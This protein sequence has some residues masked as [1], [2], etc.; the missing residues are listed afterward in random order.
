MNVIAP[1]APARPSLTDAEIIGA[2]GRR[3]FLDGGYYAANGRVK[4]VLVRD[5]GSVVEAVVRGRAPRPYE[6]FILLG[7]HS[8][9]ATEIQGRC[10]CPVGSNCKH[11]AAA[12][13]YARQHHPLAPGAFD[14]TASAAPKPA[15]VPRPVPPPEPRSP[16]IDAWLGALARTE[17]ADSEEYPSNLRHRLLYVLGTVA[18]PNRMDRLAITPVSAQL[19]K[20]GSIG[21]GATPVPVGQWREGQRPRY[22]RPSD[23]LILKRLDARTPSKSPEDDPS[24]TL[25]RIIATG[26]AHWDDVNG[27]TLAEGPALPGRLRWRLNDDASQVAV[28]E[29]DGTARPIL[30][31]DPWYA[32]PASGTIGPI[33]L[34]LTDGLARHLLAA[35]PIP[36]A[37][38]PHVRAE[39][40]RRLTASSVPVPADLPEPEEIAEPP[41]PFLRL[42]EAK[43]PVMPNW[44]RF[45]PLREETVPMA[46]LGFRYGPV[47]VPIGHRADVV[48]RDGRLYRVRPEPE[49]EKDCQ[50]R[51]EELGFESLGEAFPFAHAHR[52]RH[53][54]LLG[55][56]DP[57]S[58][59]QF[60]ARD[61][62][63][64]RKDGWEIEI[65]A[66]FP[67]RVL[68]PDG[69]FTA[70]L[71]EG[72]GIDWLELHL[73]VTLA[74]ERVELVPALVGMI[75]QLGP[76]LADALPEA[77]DEQP[78]LV[79]LLDGR[80]L[81]VPL[82]R[83]R[84]ILT[85]LIEL[86]ARGGAGREDGRIGFTRFDVAEVAALQ[87]A[88]PELVWQGGEALRAL[89][90][91]LREAGGAIPSAPMPASFQG[92]LRAYQAQGVDWL[93][94]LGGAGLGG[95]LADDMGL[96]KTVQTLAHLA[97]E[98]HAGRLD[99]PAL[100]VCPTSL[101][102]N[103]SHEARRFAPDLRLLALHGPARKEQFDQIAAHDLVIT[104]YKLIARDHAVLTA[105]EWHAVVLD[106]AQAIKNPTAETTKLVGRLQAR[107]R[108]CLSGTPLENHLGELWS[109]FDFLAPG[110]L[111]SRDQFRA[112]Y[113]TPIEKYRD[114]R[115]RTMLAARVRPFLL[116]RA[117][118]QV[119]ADLPPKTEIVEPVEME[120][121]QRAIYESVRLAM[122]DRVREAIAARGL[123]RS[124]IVIL[125]A[126][127]KM[128]QACCDPRLLKLK[129]ARQAKAGS[130]KLERLMEML[131]EL[132]EEGR[133]VLVFSQ[134]TSMLALI[135]QRLAAA[136]IPLVLLTGETKDRTTPVARF[137]SGEVSLFLLSLKA[138]GTG[139]N[140]TAAD[141]VIH[142]DPWWNPA[143]EDQ[144]TD[145]AHRIG[146]DKP[147]FVHRLVA[148]GTIEEKMDELKSRKRA[149]VAGI[150][151]AEGG[152]PLALSEA[153]I[154]LL[155]G[156]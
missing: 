75:D 38:V 56:S 128:R 114:E 136:R 7:R 138:G 102:P 98:K 130:A 60:L 35:P 120:A 96:G 16:E 129:A 122:H 111:G 70:E 76:Q 14:R 116:R 110:F 17:E 12:L 36:A 66:D 47:L 80:I 91:Q 90:Q 34:D 106:E 133:R 135:E 77:S 15:A 127:L 149:L 103:W 86:F 65:A 81:S 37:Q 19:R 49:A 139:L 59:L 22:M 142:Y 63:V 10:S 73:G 119:A 92:A 62:P 5:G 121:G 123:A 145:R 23:C 124:G 72:S 85:A 71:S 115:R 41:R 55:D 45:Q 84:P 68:E 99:R 148:L 26:R 25:R 144:A 79:P 3:A 50:D 13:I 61:V 82:G 100:I 95:V 69:G 151:D 152:S 87:Q 1:H 155:F 2:L 146:Q 32:D 27:P 39:L 83:V 107:Q 54:L 18:Q 64:L 44:G 93:Q 143:V 94:L 67:L 150:L 9:H 126:L 125:D 4:R 6:Q 154:D 108:L 53:D 156:G 140:L 134:F 28:I 11:V 24:D 8:D 58:W 137:Q 113:R 117:K 20:D 118:E 141:T 31:P 132:I 57:P 112:R 33:T 46:R 131:T 29:L 78:F 147:V 52:H 105:Q 104:T 21:G 89:G 48:A 51:L 74:G 42:F 88:A 101:V 40:K 43:A 153:D 97:I 109:L 30:L